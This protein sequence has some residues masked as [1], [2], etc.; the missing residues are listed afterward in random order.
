MNTKKEKAFTLVELAV[1]L[2]IIGILAGVVLRNI[3]SQ[4]VQAR[5]TKRIATLR[6][7]S[8]YLVQYFAK[9]GYYPTSTTETALYNA[10]VQAGIIPASSQS[11]FNFPPGSEFSYVYCSDVGNTNEP[12]HFMMRVKLEQSATQA[13]QTYASSQSIPSGW[14]CSSNVSN[15]CDTSSKYYCEGQ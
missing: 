15:W 12:N 11:D 5:D 13:P 14:S 2:L 8:T 10:L 1:V 4:S 6:N 3:G 9:Y 7:I